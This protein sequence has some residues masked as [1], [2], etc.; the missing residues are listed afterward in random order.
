MGRY[1]Q[2]TVAGPFENFDQ[3]SVFVKFWEFFSHKIWQPLACRY[4]LSF[5]E[6]VNLI[7]S[8]IGSTEVIGSGTP[9]HFNSDRISRMSLYAAVIVI[10]VVGLSP[11]KGDFHLFY[12]IL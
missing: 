12:Y 8:N 1:G 10:E 7:N 3:L 9:S 4:G 11:D 5:M 6:F 2:G